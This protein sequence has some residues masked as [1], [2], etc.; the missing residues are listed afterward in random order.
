VSPRTTD[1]PA[2]GRDRAR[3]GP[4]GWSWLLAAL[5]TVTF[6]IGGNRLLA[7]PPFV[8]RITVVN[9][10]PYVIDVD[11]TGADR[12][13]WLLLGEAEQRTTTV[14][15]E[16]LDQGSIWIVRL[17]DG[18]GGELRFTRNELVRAG[19]RVEIPT[20]TETRLRPAWGPPELH[21]R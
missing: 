11:L 16:V 6:L 9:P 3:V 8:H 2:P 21:A 13:G 14:F 5:A 10:T 18:E 15:E 12:H 19:W 1:R 20:A 7:G 4:L 17:A